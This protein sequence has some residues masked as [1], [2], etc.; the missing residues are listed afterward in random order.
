VKFL[1]SKRS[2][3]TAGVVLVLALF[4]ARP[5]AERLRT[6]IGRSISLALGRQVDVGYVY[7]RL[8]PRPGFDLKNF[9]VRDEPAFSAEPILR[10]AEATA[11]VRLTSLLRGRLEIARLSLSEPSLNLVRNTEGHWNLE[12]LL[13][14]AAKTQIA[15][16]SKAKTETRPGFPYIEADGGRINFKFGA[17]KKPYAL[18]EADFAL[19]QDSEN[20]WGMR[21]KARPLRSDFNLTDTGL[22]NVNGSWQRADSLRATPLQFS[23]QWDRAQ[24]GQ[25]SKLAYGSDKGWRGAVKISATLKGTPADLNVDSN[26]S[27]QDFRRYDIVGGGA[28]RLAARCSG[29]YSSV[30]RRL[31]NV[32]C[33]AP[34]GDGAITV[35]G[36]IAGVGSRIYDLVVKAQDVPMQ[37]LVEFARHAKK[38][39]PDDLVATGNLDAD[40][41]IRPQS[42][43]D[44]TH[45][46]WEGGGETL[47]FRVGSGLTN[48]EL[49]LDRV[50]FAVSSG[51]NLEQKAKVHTRGE[52][53]I[54]QSPAET[55]VDVG[56]FSIALGRPTPAVVGGWVSGSGYNLAI[57]G[58][59]QVRRLLQL[60][61]T[62]GLAVPRPAADGIAKMDL[63]IAGSWSGFKSPK[64]TG[65]AQLHSIRAEVRGLN[66]PL[67]IGFASLLLAQD[68][69]N[70][71]NVTASV[72]DSTWTGSLV[73]PRQCAGPGTCP[74]QFDLHADEIALEK[75]DQ[76]LNPHPRRRPWYRFL[77]AAPQPRTPYLASLHAIGKLTAS[78]VVIPKLVASRVTANVELESGKL[79]LSDLRGD[80]LG[81][82][83]LGE[84][85]ADFMTKPPVYSGSGTLERIALGQL[86]EAMHDG[87]VTGTARA[88]YRAT[89]SG[90]SAAELFSSASATLQVEVRD[91]LLPHIALVN[92]TGPLQM[93]RLVGRL[94]LRAGQF[95]IQEGKL[96]T[97]SG[98][99]RLSGTASL[100]GA[101]DVKLAH[102]VAHGFNITGGLT[103]PHVA[104]VTPA[105]TR[106]AL[107]P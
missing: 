17:E 93:R 28:L 56:P 74:V 94:V 75:L 90:L 99:Y 70:I 105:E 83:H 37:S 88:T 86:A 25:V 42:A 10:S 2:R 77:S 30:D 59:A 24:L 62:V 102:D 45:V 76:L 85:K 3:L 32:A 98:I 49:F 9:V 43:A 5:G 66:A 84:W 91:G 73:L 78:R 54:V 14:R 36:S 58:E 20:T 31:S 100:A 19:W 26:A 1:R 47:G 107:K 4:L 40:V 89:T 38:D 80:L 7:I 96:E 103:E 23:M 104:P 50:P 39:I 21:L 87:W 35:Q 53:Q 57:Q 71:Q 15:P 81:G 106:A 44:G 64:A 63:Q 60:A 18:T 61:R 55:H 8:L 101:L 29:H 52:R 97:A 6:R 82:R 51:E 48:T 16:T 12:N 41:K 72:A 69:I 65:R 68:E 46:V 33:E 34:V 22:I 95:E 67:E 27:V 11:A 79:Q 92:S 13:E